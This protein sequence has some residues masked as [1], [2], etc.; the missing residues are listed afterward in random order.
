MPY[1]DGNVLS[2]ALDVDGKTL[3][4]AQRSASLP[5]V[6]GHVAC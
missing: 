3:A 2:W 4:Q 6:K 5:F 1:W